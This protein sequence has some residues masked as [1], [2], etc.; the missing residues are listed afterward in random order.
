VDNLGSFYAA[1]I[2]FRECQLKGDLLAALLAAAEVKA[3]T[4][5]WPTSLENMPAAARE[6]F[7]A[8]PYAEGGVSVGYAVSPEGACVYSVGRKG[9]DDSIPAKPIRPIKLGPSPK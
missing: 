9:V 6:A 7:C 2:L 4:G 1:E 5:T 8:D 3:K